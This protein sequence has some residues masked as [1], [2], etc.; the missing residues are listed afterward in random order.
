MTIINEIE[1]F[2]VIFPLFNSFDSFVLKKKGR[3]LWLVISFSFPVLL[4]K[5]CGI[6]RAM[7]FLFST[8]FLLFLAFFFSNYFSSFHFA[9]DFQQCKNYS[10]SNNDTC[11]WCTWNKKLSIKAFFSF[12]S[13]FFFL[14]RD[15]F[16]VYVYVRVKWYWLTSRPNN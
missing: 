14:S 8:F 12:A 7:L 5:Y 10:R 4:I 11:K 15:S 3:S 1:N 2:I 9:L 16:F 6:T 13:S